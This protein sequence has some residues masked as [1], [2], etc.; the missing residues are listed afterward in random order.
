MTNYLPTTNLN[1]H[2][3][4][5]KS[6]TMSRK[7]QAYIRKCVLKGP[8]E[9]V[10]CP[11]RYCY[12][13]KEYVSHSNC[14]Y[15]TTVYHYSL[16]VTCWQTLIRVVH[17]GLA[18]TFSSLLYTLSHQF[19][20]FDGVCIVTLHNIEHCFHSPAKYLTCTCWYTQHSVLPPPFSFFVRGQS[21]H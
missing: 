13:V 16:M 20:T 2:R 14:I 3:I 11:G 8:S 15:D 7:D 21:Q 1:S 19:C 17:V 9:Q 6:L 12:S 4:F 10:L 5:L 18:M